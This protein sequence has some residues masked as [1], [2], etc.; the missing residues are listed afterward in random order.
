MDLVAEFAKYGQVVRIVDEH[1]DRLHQELSDL[2]YQDSI[3]GPDEA[4]IEQLL[5]EVSMN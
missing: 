5:E 1:W 3:S 4:R 2:L